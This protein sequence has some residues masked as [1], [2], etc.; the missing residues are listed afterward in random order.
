MFA[1]Y[2]TSSKAAASHARL[3]T[4]LEAD[5]GEG[6]LGFRVRGDSR[7]YHNGYLKCDAA[8]VLSFDVVLPVE[9]WRDAVWKS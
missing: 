4:A 5:L 8:E 7:R 1:V 3:C 6:L 2:S 9:T